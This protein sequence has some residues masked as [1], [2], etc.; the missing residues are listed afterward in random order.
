MANPSHTV[1]VIDNSAENCR[2]YQADLTREPAFAYE[3][4]NPAFR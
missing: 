3:V 1:L 4:I 2:R